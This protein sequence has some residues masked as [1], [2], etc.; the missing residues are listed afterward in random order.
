[1]TLDLA[2]EWIDEEELVE[3]TPASVRMRNRVLK[4]TLRNKHRA[5]ATQEASGIASSSATISR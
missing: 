1:M 2:L 4:T 3:V 5:A